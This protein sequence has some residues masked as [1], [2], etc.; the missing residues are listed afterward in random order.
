MTDSMTGEG[1][2]LVTFKL[3]SKSE[4]APT[5]QRT[6]AGFVGQ[7]NKCKELMAGM[8]FACFRSRKETRVSV[9]DINQRSS[10]GQIMGLIRYGEEIDFS[11]RRIGA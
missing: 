2:S 5:M 1:F 7:G 6:R 4:K 10:R 11:L 8:G 3:R 9:G